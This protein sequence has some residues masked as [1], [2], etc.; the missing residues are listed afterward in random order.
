MSTQYLGDHFDIHTGG[1]DHIPVHHTNE[2]AQSECCLGKKPWVNYRLHQQFLQI[3][4]GKMS[5]SK[6]H[7]LS[8]PGVEA[9]GFSPLDIRYFYLTAHYR[10]FLDFTREALEGA[11][12]TRTNMIKKIAHCPLPTSEQLR[13]HISGPL[14]QQLLEAMADDLD[15]V[16]VLSHIHTALSSASIGSSL[17]DLHDILL[18]DQQVT[19][20]GLLP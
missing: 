1:V 7:D 3:D 20:L 17:Q 8:V 18:F 9:Q 16:R 2:I 4:G 5:K 10:S 6:G 11:R 14:Y 15:T 19:K 12:S 13:T